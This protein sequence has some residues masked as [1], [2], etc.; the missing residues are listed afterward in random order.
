MKRPSSKKKA[1]L[2]PMAPDTDIKTKF[3]KYLERQNSRGKNKETTEQPSIADLL[4][5]NNNK[6]IGL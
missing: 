6:D 5:N 1:K 3:E 4:G 2:P